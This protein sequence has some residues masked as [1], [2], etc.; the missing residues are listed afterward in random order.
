MKHAVSCALEDMWT[1]TASGAVSR[2][3]S[4]YVIYDKG[5]ELIA[6]G[7][8]ETSASMVRETSI[9]IG[10]DKNVEWGDRKSRNA[11]RET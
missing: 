9:L 1:H 6:V 8:V 5:K 7:R 2:Y 4:Y 10:F 3:F 11:V